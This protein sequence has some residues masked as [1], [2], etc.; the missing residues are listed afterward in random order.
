MT[1]AQGFQW[2]GLD[3]Q[4]NRISGVINVN[5]IKD[6]Q[7]EL[8]KR[9]IEV[10]S[11]KPKLSMTLGKRKK[12]IGVKEVL[13]FTRYL[14]T[15][16]GAGL[17]IIQAL[18]IISRD[19]E[20]PTMQEFVNE[21][22][23]NTVSGKTLAESFAQ[24]PQYFSDLYVNLIRAGEK[25]GTLDKILLRLASYMEKTEALRKKV[26]KALIYPMAIVIVAGIVSL[27]LLLFVVPHFADI[28]K[29]FG[30]SLPAFT[31]AVVNLSDFL[32]S[33]WWIVGLVGFLGIYGLRYKLRTD[34]K[35]REKKDKFVLKLP[36]VGQILR[37]SIIARYTGTLAITLEAGMPI[38]EAMRSMADVMGNKLYSNAVLVIC[39]EVVSGNQLNTAMSGTKLFPNMV[40]QMISVGEASGALSDMLK[41][42][43]DYYEDEVNGLVD[44][45]SSLLEPLIMAVLGVVIGSFIIAMYLPIFKMGSLF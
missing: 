20:N 30:A 24:Y 8:K 39:D 25:S 17:P 40:I 37:K 23:V 21:L 5:D 18:E 7:A 14:S 41:K 13:L 35:F 28:F 45:L 42:I 9:N 43:A 22:R 32:Q 4:G 29:G 3:K 34:L 11:I 27:I 10:T 12:K 38:I 44:N 6:A 19:Q 31:Q 15:M 36:I 33:Y 26:K 16:V 2:Q 1:A